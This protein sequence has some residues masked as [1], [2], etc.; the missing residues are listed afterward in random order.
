MK[1]AKHVAIL[2]SL[3]WIGCGPLPAPQSN[4]PAPAAAPTAA[5]PAAGGATA[6]AAAPAADPSA[7]ARGPQ[8][9]AK[10]V[11][12]N[13][14]PD[15]KPGEIFL[16]GSMNGWNPANNDYLLKD[17][18]GDGIYSIILQLAPG[19]YQYK[20]VIDGTWTKDPYAP[21]STDDGFGGMNGKF[22]I[23]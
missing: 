15:G 1:S 11:R 16:A 12:F 6:P 10:G 9:T 13:F 7:T 23:P 22:S 8:I 20:F 17:E 21:M 3:A 14:K 19:T 4:T 5:A 18:D 2:L